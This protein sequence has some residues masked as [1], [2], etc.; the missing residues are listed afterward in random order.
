LKKITWI[1]LLSFLAPLSVFSQ[2]WHVGGFLGISN[3]SG[4]L[5]QQRVDMKYTRPTIG[6]MVKRDFNRYFTAR[7]GFQWGR[8]AAADSSNESK[9]LQARNLSFRSPIWEGSLIGEFNFFDIYE[10]GYTPYVF[11]GLALFSFYP[12]TKDSAGNSVPLRRLN[13]EGQG[14]AEYPDRQQYSLYQFA[15]PFGAG[16]K[17]LL[18]DH[19]TLGFEIGFRK[20]FT[21][22]LDDVSK[23][24][25][26]QDAL[27]RYGQRTVDFAYRGD[28]VSGHNGITPGTYP[29]EAVNR[30][31]DKKKDWYVFTGFTL[32]YRLGNGGSR[33]GRQKFSTCP[34]Y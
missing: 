9:L 12:S 24:Y 4:D 2:D 30:G 34:K 10:R 29:G 32:T 1:L 25:A 21:D 8:V 7:L 27:R 6:L 18:D 20:T 19:W 26:D 17:A 16:I 13:T 14:L 15:I 23:T 11:G 31:S 28:E 5:V 33:Y 3:Y 22:Y